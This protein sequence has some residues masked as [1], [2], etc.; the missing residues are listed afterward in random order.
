M[1]QR[2]LEDE[3]P[4]LRPEERSSLPWIAA[5]LVVG[6]LGALAWFT[7]QP[8]HKPAPAAIAEQPPAPPAPA[9]EPAVR[10]PL[11]ETPPRPLPALDQS[12]SMMRELLVE[13]LGRQAFTDY[14]IPVQLVRRIVATVDNLPRRA[15]PRRMMPLNPVP[16]HFAVTPEGD[17]FTLDPAN[18]S[19]YGAHVRALEA[20]PARALVALY[21]QSYPLFQR[22]YEELGY[23]GR[24]FNDR[25]IEALDDLLAAPELGSTVRL[26]R[27]KVLY[28][29]ADPDLETRSA[30]QK[31]L[32]RIGA[33]GARRVK[34]KLR[35]IRQEIAAA[36][37]RRP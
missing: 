18:A 34:A 2:S 10:N 12:D 13:L 5:A 1:E 27:P 4:Y 30:G 6:A 14:W 23:P 11:P 9:T 37:A 35:E 28:E 26:L 3:R 20:I 15:A 24:Y 19:R 33:E 32:M 21:V 8:E 7:L 29:F 31:V 22:A 16:G 17:A 36:G 25:L